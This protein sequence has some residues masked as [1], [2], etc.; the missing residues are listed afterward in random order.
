MYLKYS[1]RESLGLHIYCGQEQKFLD[2][3][4]SRALVPP[5]SDLFEHFSDKLFFD[6][7]KLGDLL[8]G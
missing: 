8:V 2:S 6:S 5:R 4:T 1:Y 3:T 7:E